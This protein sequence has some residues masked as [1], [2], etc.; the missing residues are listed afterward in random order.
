MRKTHCDTRKYQVVRSAKMNENRNRLNIVDCA[1][2]G[3]GDG[4]V[5]LLGNP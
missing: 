3:G 4:N 5:L 1:C 2:D